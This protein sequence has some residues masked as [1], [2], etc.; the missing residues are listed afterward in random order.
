MQRLEARALRGNIRVEEDPARRR[1]AAREVPRLRNAGLSFFR[2]EDSVFV[3]KPRKQNVHRLVMLPSVELQRHFQASDDRRFKHLTT[4]KRLPHTIDPPTPADSEDEDCDLCREEQEAA[5]KAAEEERLLMEH[6]YDECEACILDRERSAMQ[7]EDRESRERERMDRIFEKAMGTKRRDRER[8]SY[9]DFEEEEAKGAKR[10]DQEEDGYDNFEENSD[11]DDCKACERGRERWEQHS[12]RVEDKVNKMPG[13][14]DK[15]AE[16]RTRR[17]QQQEAQQPQDAAASPRDSYEDEFEEADGGAGQGQGQPQQA[18]G[19]G[20]AE[21]EPRARAREAQDAQQP[22][23][24]AE[25]SR[26]SYEEEFDEDDE[27]P[28]AGQA[29]PPTAGQSQAEG[30]QHA[31]AQE[32]DYE[33]FE[34]REA[35]P[36]VGIG[37]LPDLD[38]TWVPGRTPVARDE[39]PTSHESQGT[40]LRVPSQPPL[41]HVDSILGEESERELLKSHLLATLT[42]EPQ[43]SPPGSAA[44]AGSADGASRSQSPEPEAALAGGAVEEGAPQGTPTPPAEPDYDD[45]GFETEDSH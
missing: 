19:P 7:A 32:D 44:A 40:P 15:E 18:P 13:R 34:D 28:D 3:P 41:Q 16:E 25:G 31:R 42:P 10:R 29:R 22:E 5:A 45:E 20:Q 24:E 26:D 23:A 17:Q 43:P 30:E 4:L 39:R 27:G 38:P 1:A 12:M 21:G 36:P 8:D 2:E 14:I 35:A 37:A 33:G 6:A 9:E 11:F